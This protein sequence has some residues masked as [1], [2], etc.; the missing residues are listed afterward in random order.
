MEFEYERCPDYLKVIN[1]LKAKLKDAQDMLEKERKR[2]IALEN[3]VKHEKEVNY[4]L[5][6]IIQKYNSFN[7]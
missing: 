2:N 5:C 6:D 1:E 3:R 7:K 4:T